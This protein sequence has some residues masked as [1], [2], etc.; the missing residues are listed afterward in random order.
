MHASLTTKQNQTKNYEK[1]WVLREGNFT[2]TL[3]IVR[4]E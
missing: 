3:Y 1:K 2:T 4:E